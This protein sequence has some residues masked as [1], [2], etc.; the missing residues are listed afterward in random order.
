MSAARAGSTRAPWSMPRCTGI[1][2]ESSRARPWRTPTAGTTWHSCRSRRQSPASP[3]GPR[4]SRPSRRW[5]P[6][7]RCA[8]TRRPTRSSAPRRRRS[9]GPGARCCR[10]FP[11]R[12]QR[13]RGRRGARRYGVWAVSWPPPPSTPRAWASP[14]R[15]W[16]PRRPSSARPCWPQLPPGCVRSTATRCTGQPSRSCR[17][18]TWAAPKNRERRLRTVLRRGPPAARVHPDA[19]AGG[20]APAAPPAVAALARG[21]RGSSRRCWWQRGG[22]L[23][24]PPRAVH[25]HV[26]HGVHRPVLAGAQGRPPAAFRWRLGAGPARHGAADGRRGCGR[27]GGRSLGGRRQRHGVRDQPQ[28]ASGKQQGAGPER[29]RV[30]ADARHGPRGDGLHAEALASRRRAATSSGGCCLFLRGQ[31]PQQQ[32]EPQVQRL[33]QGRL[34]AHARRGVRA[35]EPCVDGVH[36]S[37]EQP[38]SRTCS[39]AKAALCSEW[40]CSS[41]S[42]AATAA[43]TASH[44]SAGAAPT[45]AAERPKLSASREEVAKTR[46]TRRSAG[47]LGG[48][49]AAAS[50]AES[51]GSSGHPARATSD[52]S[53][54]S[55]G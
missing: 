33:R 35:E 15:P 30:R 45:A 17:C 47:R 37:S 38:R 7:P 4:Q 50:W 48:H 29:L 1:P 44:C 42:Q 6:T 2:C 5:R 40:P 12:R 24:E 34:D 36:G 18:G 23:R 19:L 9:P 31:G 16:E 25:L 49:A 10:H 8:T 14:R 43:S 11:P 27:R 32:A 51:G 26:G 53:E 55:C 52:A 13:R 41:R 39:S 22:G 21:G 46:P 3:R 20:A 28:D 54:R